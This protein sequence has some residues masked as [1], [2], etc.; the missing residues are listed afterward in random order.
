MLALSLPALPPLEPV[1]FGGWR[2][3]QA[4]HHD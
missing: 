1:G 3:V 2:L 4:A